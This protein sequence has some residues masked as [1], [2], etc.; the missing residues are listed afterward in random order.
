MAYLLSPAP[1]TPGHQG[2]AMQAA[3]AQ[4]LR[5]RRIGIVTAIEGWRLTGA[6]VAEPGGGQ[7]A[8][9]IPQFGA[10]VRIKAPESN[11]YGLISRIWLRDGNNGPAGAIAMF[12]I[13]ILGEIVE[14][15]RRRPASSGAA[16]RPIRTSAP[17]SLRPRAR[18]SRGSMRCPDR[19]TSASAPCTRTRRSRSMSWSTSC[20][21]ATSP[22]SAPP[23]RASPVR[24][25]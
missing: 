1:R 11:L 20:S 2:N 5:A 8:D 9:T 22:C 21:V 17:R 25:R 13:E 18:R 7:A 4:P 14:S 23:A 15:R 19:P 16:S 12:E 10:L 3:A 6:V 24:R